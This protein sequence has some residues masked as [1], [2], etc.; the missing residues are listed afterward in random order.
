MPPVCSIVI[1]FGSIFQDLIAIS[2]AASLE[3]PKRLIPITL[4]RSCC[5]SLISGRE[6]S[7]IGSLFSNVATITTGAPRAAAITDED[8]AV[9]VN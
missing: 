8:A 1:S 7:S 5:G 2:T 3:P 9:W 4:P 6:T